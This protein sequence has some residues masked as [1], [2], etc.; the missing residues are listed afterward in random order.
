MDSPWIDYLRTFEEKGQPLPPFAEQW[1]HYQALQAEVPADAPPPVAWVPDAE[2]LDH[3]NPARWLRARGLKDHAA[4]HAW[5][6]N[7]PAAF[8]Q[9]VI[10]EL[11][12][13]HPCARPEPQIEVQE[14]KALEWLLKGAQ[15]SDTARN[16]LTKKGVIARFAAAKAGKAE[17]PVKEEA[18]SP[19][20][21][22]EAETE[23]AEA[24]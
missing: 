18:E 20:A 6:V 9:A 8:W 2:R 5:S 7:E 24:Q 14:D 13:Y 10:D 23:S 17:A 21:P 22:V 12:I 19:E 3:S 4:L 16:I 1:T 11:G 15:P